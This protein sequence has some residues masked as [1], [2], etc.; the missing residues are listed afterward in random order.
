MLDNKPPCPRC[1]NSRIVERIAGASMPDG[2][3]DLVPCPKCLDG[4]S[5][6]PESQ[7]VRQ[8]SCYVPHDV[9]GT[10]A[11]AALE[12]YQRATMTKRER[13]QLGVVN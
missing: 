9:T 12:E 11:N 7:T 13:L 5:Y 6:V 8:P 10:E 2:R 1:D 3:K 4:G